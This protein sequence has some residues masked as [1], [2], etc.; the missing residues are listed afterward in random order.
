MLGLF[1]KK[2]VKLVA[3]GDK[4]FGR[5]EMGLAR[6]EYLAALQ[7]F[8]DGDDP[9]EK[10][11]VEARLDEVCVTLAK[12]QLEEAK[13]HLEAGL[14][15]RAFSI[16][17]SVEDL[18]E[19]RDEAT[20]A[21]A[22]AL[23]TKLETGEIGEEADDPEREVKPVSD[24]EADFDLLVSTLPEARQE[25]YRAAG[26][27]FRTGYLLLNQGEAVGAFRAFEE[28][29][30]GPWVY[31]EM[32]RAAVVLE[33]YRDAADNFAKAA[34]GVDEALAAPVFAGLASSSIRCGRPE[35]AL[36]A[37][38]RHTAIE[39]PDARES[40]LLEMAVLS[41]IGREKDAET[42]ARTFLKRNPSQI[43]VW[44]SLGLL[45]E[46]M[47][48]PARAVEAYE[49]V[50]GLRWRFDPDRRVV[51]LDSVSTSRLAELL[52]M[53]G[54]GEAL[55]RALTLL[56][57]LSLVLEDDEK[58]GLAHVRARV[59]AK[60]GDVDGARATLS[61]AL[62]SDAEIPDQGRWALQA[63]LEELSE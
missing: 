61:E 7:A 54:E 17:E 15:D 13:R 25:A 23:L 14:Y 10:A 63:Q 9:A 6:G 29:V 48:K 8:R 33:K 30:S 26:P 44:R 32:A 22:D 59:L 53:H 62:A 46:R 52:A 45:L 12:A 36:D 58:W 27:K 16:L 21:A 60:Q 56:N 4:C 51:D 24:P 40:V 49:A 2:F 39:G 35:V 37:V 41:G 55:D 50:M 3:K 19:G 20:R 5:G 42:A 18:A 57:A 34:D 43:A 1:R 47:E 28:A 31:Y 38:E 11:R